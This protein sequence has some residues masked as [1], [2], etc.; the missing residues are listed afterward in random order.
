MKPKNFFIQNLFYK[1]FF[2][3]KILINFFLKFF[4]KKIF[5]SFFIKN[6]KSIFFK[7]HLY[8]LSLIGQIIFLAIILLF[9]FLLS[10]YFSQINFLKKNSNY[11][12]I[13]NSN[14]SYFNKIKIHDFAFQNYQR[15]PSR[16]PLKSALNI[17]T[18]YG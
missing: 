14:S 11:Y 1:L 8:F 15:N 4:P 13:N 7:I 2:K 3:T 17:K 12:Q 5:N 9:L 16:E 18:D 10:V 6:L